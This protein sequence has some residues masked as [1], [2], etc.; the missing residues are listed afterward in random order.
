[1][2]ELTKHQEY[3]FKVGLNFASIVGYVTAMVF[4]DSWVGI[5]GIGTVMAYN[6]VMA[7]YWSKHT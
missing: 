7:Y 2:P 1:M 3:I 6:I 5:V 4:H